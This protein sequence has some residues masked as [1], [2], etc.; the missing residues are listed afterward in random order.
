MWSGLMELV[1]WWTTRWHP[2]AG[3]PGVWRLFVGVSVPV[4]MTLLLR[5][6]VKMVLCHFLVGLGTMVPSLGTTQICLN[7][8][9]NRDDISHN[10]SVLETI[11][12]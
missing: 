3:I 7:C 1:G 8:I 10:V 6:F 9:M 4:G 11:I 5:M 2:N 12:G